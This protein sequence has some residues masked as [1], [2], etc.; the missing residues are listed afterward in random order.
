MDLSQF[1]D[2]D[3]QA[4]ASGDL[5]KV[6]DAGL[7]SLHTAAGG[8]SMPRY[9]SGQSFDATSQGLV[10]SGSPE[11]LAGQ[12]PVSGN[13]FG[14]NVDIGA[15]QAFTNAGQRLH[16]LYNAITG[17]PSLD[18]EIAAK[19]T[20]DAPINATGGG[21]FGGAVAAAP[22]AF[23]TG[24][25]GG[26]A[27]YGASL[28][29]LQPT[30]STDRG[31]TLGATAIN[32]GLGAATGAAGYGAGKVISN[33]LTSRAAQPFM[34][35]NPST[36]N[37]VAAEAVGSEAPNLN[38]A[39]LADVNSRLGAV[40]DRARDPNAITYL[41]ADT[42]AAVDSA[43][44]G[45]NRSS[46]SALRSNPDVQ[47]LLGSVNGATN[48][49]Q[50]G[51]ISSRLGREAAGQ[52]SGRQGDRA[53]G[54]ALFAVKGHVDD[55]IGQTI[56]DPELAAAYNVA[57]GQYRALSQVSANSSILNSSTGDVNM[58]ALGKYL[59]RTDKAGYMRGGNTS[60]LYNAA[61]WG[62]ATGVGRGSPPLNITGDLGLKWLSYQ[63][64]NNPL[65]NA[66]G[67]AV[68]RIGAPLAPVLPQGLEGLA[69]GS[70]PIAIPYL[71]Q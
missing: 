33:W 13:T 5:T 50:L 15:G 32:T 45:L 6:S 70:A 41:G 63:A 40:F 48:A 34:G 17:G 2:A 55:L 44:S 31:G 71:E 30:M 64:L 37:R 53:L 42:A 66:A 1:S 12:S 68:S 59:Q 20:M 29:A 24:G 4:L 57:R 22:A 28:G 58:T 19:R 36:A 61:R 65:S 9:G 47:D 18:A 21:K 67:G 46:E 26:A 62:Q 25:L 7:Q 52:M 51:Q 10:P 38:Q 35:W 39:A 11:A 3:L 23:L 69:I 27:L 56:S 60:E 49:Q 14:E 43:A 54:Q 16:Q 8:S